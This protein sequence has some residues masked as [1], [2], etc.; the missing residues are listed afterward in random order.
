MKFIYTILNVQSPARVTLPAERRRE[1]L[2][3]AREYDLIILEDNSY[4][5][6]RFE[7][8]APPTLAT[9]EQVETGS[10]G[11]VVYLGTFSK[12]FAPGVRLGKIGCI[13]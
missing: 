1:L 3:I 8:E 11:R 5:M 9:L 13:A 2:D 7:G 4:S 10:V 12:I 6:L